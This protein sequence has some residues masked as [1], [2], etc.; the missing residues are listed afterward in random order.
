LKNIESD[1][2]LIK[3]KRN[4]FTRRDTFGKIDGTEDENMLEKFRISPA[5]VRIKAKEKTLKLTEAFDSFLEKDYNIISDELKKALQYKNKYQLLN[6][7]QKLKK[8]TSSMNFEELSEKIEELQQ[9]LVNS[10]LD[11]LRLTFEDFVPMFNTIDSEIHKFMEGEK[12]ENDNLTCKVSPVEGKGDK[13]NLNK[14]SPFMARR[15]IPIQKQIVNSSFKEDENI[16]SELNMIQFEGFY[17]NLTLNKDGIEDQ[18]YTSNINDE[19]KA[20]V[21]MNEEEVK[22]KGKENR[23]SKHKSIRGMV[24]KNYNP[25]FEYPF[26]EET[27]TCNIL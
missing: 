14:V 2:N 17:S 5:I 8:Y 21:S 7:F 4:N 15:N 10:N 13:T 6:V 11:T 26:K 18:I 23:I 25:N 12:T 9:L 20:F 24:N 1:D 19:L 27:I 22:T 3:N 16:Y